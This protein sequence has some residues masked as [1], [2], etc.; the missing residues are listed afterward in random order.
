MACYTGTLLLSGPR[1]V[2]AHRVWR[3]LPRIHASCVSLGQCEWQM[4]TDLQQLYE[5][6]DRQHHRNTYNIAITAES[7]TSI[8]RSGRVE[9]V[10]IGAILRVE[11]QV[12]VG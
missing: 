1:N 9:A 7:A 2:D 5:I 3:R 10:G 11:T 4:L 12:H 8:E 6:Q